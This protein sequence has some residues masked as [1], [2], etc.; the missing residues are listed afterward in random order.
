MIH[1]KEGICDIVKGK[2][3]QGIVDRIEGGK[4][5]SW[6]AIALNSGGNSLKAVLLT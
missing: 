4:V 5:N 2:K 6:K 1:L 3:F